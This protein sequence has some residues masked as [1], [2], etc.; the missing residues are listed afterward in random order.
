MLGLDSPL[1]LEI[2]NCLGPGLM[3]INE[4]AYTIENGERLTLLMA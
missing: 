4:K 3:S 2:S 1:E